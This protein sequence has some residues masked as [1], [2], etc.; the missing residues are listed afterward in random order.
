MTHPW[1][2]TYF[3]I[4]S[5]IISYLISRAIARGRAGE[6]TNEGQVSWICPSLK[7]R[8]PRESHRS[9]VSSDPVAAAQWG[10]FA[11]SQFNFSS[12]PCPHYLLSFRILP[13]H[14]PTQNRSIMF[15]C[16]VWT[17]QLPFPQP[18][19]LI[20]LSFCSSSLTS[21]TIFL[22]TSYFSGVLNQSVA[23]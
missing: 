7:V 17:L 6:M 15:V 3:S 5:Y 11:T 23:K 4:I 12:T 14:K 22:H 10:S 21:N 18:S 16:Y 1:T 19:P 2:S 13:S 20:F 8:F 9:P